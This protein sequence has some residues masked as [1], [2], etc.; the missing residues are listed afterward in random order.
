VQALATGGCVRKGEKGSA[1]MSTRYL[2]FP[3]MLILSISRPNATFLRC[4]AMI[5]IR[6]GEAFQPT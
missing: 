1:V 6:C 3:I 4:D 5:E 2:L